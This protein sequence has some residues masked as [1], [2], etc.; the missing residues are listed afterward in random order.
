M[1]IPEFGREKFD[2]VSELYKDISKENFATLFAK[3]DYKEA[4]DAYKKIAQDVRKAQTEGKPY[5]KEFDWGSDKYILTLSMTT[6]IKA[7]AYAKCANGS[8]YVK[9]EGTVTVQKIQKPIVT[10]KKVQE[11]EPV[12]VFTQTTET[13]KSKQSKVLLTAALAGLNRETEQTTEQPPVHNKKA[14][15]GAATATVTNKDR[16]GNANNGQIA[17]SKTTYDIPNENEG[18]VTSH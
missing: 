6:A 1:L 12:T 15:Q 7:G 8:F 17:Q 2:K 14:E 18:S 4:L 5:T 11:R 13:I 10:E 16:A 3:A 9:E